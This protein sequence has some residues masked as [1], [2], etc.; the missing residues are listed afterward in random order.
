MHEENSAAAGEAAPAAPAVR[1][2]ANLL[3]DIP[4]TALKLVV[5]C[6]KDSDDRD[7]LRLV[8]HVAHLLRRLFSCTAAARPRGTACGRL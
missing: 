8:R 6:L 3:L 1:A 7:S 4:E 5:A 2:A